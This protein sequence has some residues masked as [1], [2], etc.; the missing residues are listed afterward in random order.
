MFARRISLSLIFVS[1]WLS[2]AC[3]GR[4][5]PEIDTRGSAEVVAMERLAEKGQEIFRDRDFGETGVACIDC[6]A[7]FDEDRNPDGR[8]RPGHSIL[9]AHA[10]AHAWNGEFTGAALRHTGAGAAKCAWQ[11]Q[12]RGAGIETALSEEEAAALIAFYEYISPDEQIPMLNWTAVTWPGDPDFEKETFE[13][14]LAPI[15]KLRGDQ[16]RGERVYDMACAS[17]HDHG[18]A[19]AKRILK[20]KVDRLPAVVRAG[21]D[22]MPFFSRNKLSDQDI[23]DVKAFVAR[24]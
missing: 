3:G 6:H 22:G 23:A 11:F 17:C 5:S 20:R 4:E 16:Q 12:E 14:A 19:P 13:Q 10:R 2:A 15:E 24:Q 8:I 9:G 1:L 21:E 7:D 18:I